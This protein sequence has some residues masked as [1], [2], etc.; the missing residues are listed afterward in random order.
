MYLS[1]IYT[2]ACNLAGLPA[3]SVPAGFTDNMPVGL[4]L[5]GNYLDEAGI[6]NVAH[7]YQQLTNWHNNRPVNFN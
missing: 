5:I 7:Q 3:M 2:I 4:H 6:L 1:D